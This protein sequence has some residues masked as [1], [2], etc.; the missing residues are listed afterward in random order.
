M[1]GTTMARGCRSALHAVALLGVVACSPGTKAPGPDADDSAAVDTAA[2]D[3]GD[4]GTN[5]ATRVDPGPPGRPAACLMPLPPLAP[6]D[7]T[8]ADTDPEVPELDTAGLAAWWPLDGDWTDAFGGH[9]LVPLRAGGFA[10]AAVARPDGNG[11][12]GPTGTDTD[13][14]ALGADFTTLDASAGLTLETWFYK[15]GN[16]TSGT[17]IGWG[18]GTWA[19]PELRLADSWGALHFSAGSGSR[20]VTATFA[21]PSAGCWHHLALVLRP[22]W[23][24]GV[25][26]EVWLDGSLQVP[27][28]GDLVID[29]P[30]HLFGRPFQL[31]TWRLGDSVALRID[32]A[33]AWTRALSP[34]ELALAATPRGTGERCP[35]TSRAWEPGPRCDF[36]HVATPPFD[37]ARTARF[38]TDDTV[39]LVSDPSDWLES[40]LQDGC[41]AYLSAMEAHRDDLQDWWVGYQYGFSALETKARYLPPLLRA[42]ADDDAVLSRPCEDDPVPATILSRWT[43]PVS[44]WRIT[45]A[46]PSD[47]SAGEGGDVNTG[48]ART[49]LLTWIRL[50]R[51]L[52]DGEPYAIRD[53]WGERFEGVYDADTTETW[54]L[55]LSQTGFAADDPGKRAL[56][57][58][59][60]GPGGALDLGRFVGRPFQVVDAATG[61]VAYEGTVAA[62]ADST[63]ATG[64]VLA[65]LD[66]G[67]LTTPGRYRVRLPG[68]GVT[69]PFDIGPDAIGVAFLAHARGLYHNRCAPLD[70]SVTPWAR[71]DIHDVFEAAFPP[72]VDDYRDHAAAGWGFTDSAGRY[73]S[74]SNFEAVT[75]TATTTPR[76]I[77]GGWHDAGDYDRRPMHLDIVRD[78]ALA[79]LLAPENFGDGQLDLPDDART[80]GVPD[81]LDEAAW[82]LAAYRD[83]QGADGRVG[84]WMEATSHPQED[85]PGADTQPYYLSL[86]TR[87]S[88]LAYAR[89]AALLSRAL[90][91]AGDADGADDWLASAEN[92]W[93]FGTR[94]DVRVTAT[95][96]VRGQALTWRERPQPDGERRMLAAVALFGAT[97][98]PSYRAELE[99]SEVEA[100]FVYLRDNAWW[101]IRGMDLAEVALG[102][103]L[104]A[105]WQEDAVDTIVELAEGWRVGQTAWPYGWA[106]YAP[107]HRYVGNVGWGSGLYKPL[108]ELVLAWKFTGDPAYRASAL[109]GL[110][111]LQGANPQGRSMTTGLGTH[112]FVSALHLPSFADDVA[113]ASPGLTIYGAGTGLA[114]QAGT[115]VWGLRSDA[116]TDPRFEGIDR[117]L[118]P[119]PWDGDTLTSADAQAAASEVLPRWR[120]LVPLESPLPQ[121]MEFT[122]WETIGPAMMVTGLLLDPGWTP[123]EGMLADE[124]LDVEQWRENLWM[125]P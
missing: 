18:D 110:A 29:D 82:G 111:Y 28:R 69:P 84:T 54:A 77:T 114:S 7:D 88:S 51:A 53:A 121:N 52:Q 73:V 100:A 72:D 63:E 10:D 30:E 1:D 91:A 103:D 117:A 9:D 71:G 97:G 74:V 4:T 120:R 12:Y 8:G 122:V 98:A 58:H 55:K 106:W 104:P 3:T 102:D 62:L 79:Y 96:T 22:G 94:E 101:Q 64:E 123:T 124:P 112:R 116:R 107:D 105:G 56:L 15:A 14:G 49:T 24:A 36:R 68:A 78:L 119:P 25:P 45:R 95:M 20:R 118:L 11:T 34:E 47:G 50:P 70:P 38:L 27:E 5:G 31:G 6:T 99:R 37:T 60:M 13:N 65:S 23:E 83:A 87:D 57:G 93:A 33:R 109:R 2:P 46:A 81:V 86:G 108:R 40:R 76:S 19:Q 75:A 113:E 59:F 17:L 26:A 35:S 115:H 80:N 42:W 66:F 16:N 90:R 125:M 41:G 39:V 21:R 32:E 44:E 48:A 92:A 43:Q 89:H 61:A 67:A 85:D